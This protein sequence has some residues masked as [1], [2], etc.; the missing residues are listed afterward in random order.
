MIAKIAFFGT[1]YAASASKFS[2]TYQQIAFRDSGRPG[3]APT[4]TGIPFVGRQGAVA[5]SANRAT[6]R[7]HSEEQND[8]NPLSHKTDS[9]PT[10]RMTSGR[11]LTAL[12]LFSSLPGTPP[13]AGFYEFLFCSFFE[14]SCPAPRQRPSTASP[15]APRQSSETARGTLGNRGFC[16]RFGRR[17]GC[18]CFKNLSLFTL[19][20]SPFALFFVSLTS[21]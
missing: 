4:R 21:S 7:C 10:L 9:S 19:R 13:R 18:A 16:S 8:E 20:L 6:E 1:R 5:Q 14:K 3:N 2:I 15:T 17:F 12:R 11:F